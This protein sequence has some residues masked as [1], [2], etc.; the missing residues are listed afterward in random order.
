[1]KS[2]PA[3]AVV[4]AIILV[5]IGASVCGSE[6][7]PAG[8]ASTITPETPCIGAPAPNHFQ[9]VILVMEENHSFKQVIGP[10]AYQTGLARSCGLA[11]ASYAV[12]YPSLPNYIA[13]TSGAVP[14]SVAGRD[15]E[16]TGGCLTNRRSI[17]TQS[18]SWKVY[19]ESMPSACSRANTAN[20]LY[21]PRHTAAPYFTGVVGCA[22]KDVPLGTPTAGALHHDL[23]VGGLPRFAVIAPNTTDDAHGG[24]L[25]CAD[26]WLARWLPAI[27]RSRAY[28]SGST[29]VFITYD[30]D[31]GNSQNH[32]PTVVVAPS[33]PE[34]T[35]VKTRFT[36]YALLRTM[37]DILGLKGHLGGAATARSMAPG[38]RLG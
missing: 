5:M 34:G 24:C 14:A 3:L 20:G 28:Q 19:A 18:R 23:T 15:C 4:S 38:F 11:A 12:T 30:S 27:I 8:A 16:P 32:I 17:F 10:E 2:L 21:V 13:L 35:V 33:V 25:T 29:A 1:M 9:H 37:E 6:L 36:H 26:R 7:T 22:Q 31:D